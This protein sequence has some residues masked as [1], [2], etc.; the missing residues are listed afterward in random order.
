MGKHSNVFIAFGKPEIIFSTHLDVVPAEPE[1]FRPRIERGRLY[2]R[3]ACDAKGVAAAMIAAAEALLQTG[4]RN[5]GLLFVTGEELDGSGARAASAALANR[6]VRFLV[7]GEPTENRVITA[8]KGGLGFSLK[9]S[10]LSA[11]SG[12]PECGV[13]ANRKLIKVLRRLLE[14]DWGFDNELGRGSINVGKLQANNAANV[15][16]WEASAGGFIRSVGDHRELMDRV[17][18]L[19]GE[20]AQV[21]VDYDCPGARML[22]VPGIDSAVAAFC[23]DIPNF[24]MPGLQTVLYGPGSISQAHTSDEFLEV[25]SLEKAV[26]DYRKIFSYLKSM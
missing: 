9:A 21:S 8:H 13:D 6:G 15:V 17:R 20:D 3:G 10:G 12:Y 25:S 23:T 1:K 24:R 19:A 4:E 16:S 26:M 2:G 22:S 11:H 7:N 18:E 5:F 14:T